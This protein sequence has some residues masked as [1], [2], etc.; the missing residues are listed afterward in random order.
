MSA[1]QPTRTLKP[2]WNSSARWILVYLLPVALLVVAFSLEESV[3]TS[4]DFWIPALW[5]F[6][7]PFFNGAFSPTAHRKLFVFRDFSDN[8]SFEIGLSILHGALW[9][10]I[11][12]FVPTVGLQVLAFMAAFLVY[13][14]FMLR[15][16]LL[17][18]YAFSPALASASPTRKVLSFGLVWWG[19]LAIALALCHLFLTNQ[20]FDIILGTLLIILPV[21]LGLSL[22]H[23][24]QP[25]RLAAKRVAVIGA[26][27]SGIYAVKWLATQGIEVEGFDQKPYLGGVWK[28]DQENAG[29]VFEHTIATSSKYFMHASDLSIDT[30]FPVFPT[31]AQLWNYLQQYVKHF[32]LERFFRLK[33]CVERV[34]KEQDQWIVTGTDAE[35][36]PFQKA[37][38][39]VVVASGTSQVPADWAERYEGFEGKV[40]HSSHYKSS[41]IVDHHERVLVV[42]LGESAAD[43]AYECALRKPRQVVWSGQG[44]QWFA[45]RF[46]GGYFA[47]DSFLAPGIRVVMSRFLALEKFARNF[48]QAYMYILWGEGNSGIK[49]W[50]PSI[51]WLHSFVT[52]SRDAIE[53]IHQGLIDPAPKVQSVSGKT[54]TFTDGSI[55]EVDLIIDCTGF[56]TVY[57]F[58]DQPVEFQ[59]LYQLVFNPADPTLSFVGTARPTLGS[60][61]G[62]AEFQARWIGATYSGQVP[63]PHQEQM[64]TEN[65]YQ[66][67]VNRYRYPKSTKRSNLVDHEFY[68][69]RIARYLCITVPWLRLLLTRPNVFWLLI[70]S[71]WM[72]F[73][74]NLRSK[75]TRE[76][77]VQNIRANQPLPGAPLYQFVGLFVILAIPML[78]VFGYLVYLT[79]ANVPPF[80]LLTYAIM[81]LIR[82]V[83]KW[84]VAPEVNTSRSW[85][86]NTAPVVSQSV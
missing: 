28:Y 59:D 13:D 23:R 37:F 56:K 78:F 67:K 45:G 8:E 62:L 17:Q 21:Q 27:W 51:P 79:A 22:F 35:G 60:I 61:P 82:Y 86:V 16:D 30:S 14:W 2:G 53:F 71:P 46:V 66:Q 70:K 12:Q 69:H 11:V 1:P 74:Y 3:L 34:R 40:I 15:Y 63:L 65:Y 25:Q 33:H 20:P 80:I 6:W 75:E 31:H 50:E 72:A 18:I 43:I 9:F 10:L 55:Q 54:I 68:V 47:A 42:G 7:M 58:L 64:E 44:G 32:N 39:A 83:I 36:A 85:R 84:W 52:K 29:G 48:I 41:D 19:Y 73:N 77:A 24:R 38:D 5:G 76:Q 4:R 26:G 81:I 57:P 49:C